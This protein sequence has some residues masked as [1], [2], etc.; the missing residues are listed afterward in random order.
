MARSVSSSVKTRK[1]RTL[2]K[3]QAKS[4]RPY[5]PQKWEIRTRRALKEKV[6]GLALLVGFLDQRFVANPFDKLLADFLKRIA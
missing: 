4:Q 5:R 3:R 2:A 6:S 1:P